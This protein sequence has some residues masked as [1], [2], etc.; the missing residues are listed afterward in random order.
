MSLEMCKDEDIEDFMDRILSYI[1]MERTPWPIA[2]NILIVNRNRKFTL[3][4]NVKLD[5]MN[6]IGWDRVLEKGKTKLRREYLRTW[7]EGKDDLEYTYEV[8]FV[9]LRR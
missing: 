4:N 9:R 1:D 2:Q 5:A 6:K 3:L 8:V 7:E